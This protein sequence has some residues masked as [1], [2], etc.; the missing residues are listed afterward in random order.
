MIV[1]MVFCQRILALASFAG[2]RSILGFS[3]GPSLNASYREILIQLR[4]VKTE[5]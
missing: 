3:E 4:P 5:R 1:T 2:N